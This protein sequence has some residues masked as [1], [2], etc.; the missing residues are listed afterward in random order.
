ML[1]PFLLPLFVVFPQGSSSSTATSTGVESAKNNL[2]S[3]YVNAW[4]NAGFGSDKLVSPADSQWVFRN[5]DSGQMA[6]A[7]SLGM[8]NAWD[9]SRLDAL[10]K[11]LNAEEENVRGGAV[12]GLALMACGTRN[13]D[14]DPMLALLGMHLEE[15]SG[16]G[17][18]MKIGA[19]YGLGLVY[20]GSAREDVAEL[21]TPY[22]AAASSSSSS[23]SSSAAAGAGGAGAAGGLGS[24]DLSALGAAPGTVGASNSPLQPTP[25]NA[26]F[27]CACMAALALGMVFVGTAKEDAASTIADR[28]MSATSNEQNSA[29]ARHMALG[30]GLLFLGQGEACEAMLEILTVV[31]EA[32]PALAKLSKTL[33]KSCAY[34]G[35]G[36]VLC[37]QELLQV[38]AAHPEIEDKEKDQKAKE[39]AD[40]K[41]AADAVAAGPR[42]AA[43]GAGAGA[44]AGG[45]GGAA[46]AA[47]AAAAASASS[48]SS[49]ASADNKH[50]ANAAG[51]YLDQS[52]AVLGLALVSLGEDLSVD[53]ATRM[54]DHLLQYG[55]TSVRR[56]VPI[57]LGLLHASEPDYAIVDTLSKLSHDPNLET[58]QAAIF[59]M[60]IVSAG[61]NNS[62]VAG[63][64]RT[65]SV[66]YKDDPNVLFVIRLAQGLTHMGKGLIGLNPI[67]ADRNLLSPVALA[68]LLSTLLLFL[69]VKSSL[70]GTSKWHILLYSLA[71]T[72]HPRFVT[73]ISEDL[74]DAKPMPVEVRVGTAVDTVGQAGRPKT[75]TGFQTHSTPVLIGTKDRAELVDE[76]FYPLTPII[77]GIVIL[78]KN[79]HYKPQ[80]GKGTMA[81]AIA[82]GAGAGGAGG[83]NK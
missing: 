81:G 18:N 21:L 44:G 50:G 79:P 42:G 57:A 49:D 1:S 24:L 61:T 30:L 14:V 78:R 65:L 55:D 82:G 12:L 77:E 73:T 46:A 29:I 53:M 36:N 19:L 60:G 2:A 35:T 9:E 43:G 27:D 76:A 72:M 45:A 3:T 25:S 13:L 7:A 5:K 83:T 68:G 56:M 69:D 59:S 64:L 20:A 41:V 37:I 48:S 70:H 33:L 17:Q 40:R 22:I 54:A 10:D 39:E 71:M 31:E 16:A 80:K 47:A 63:L 4:V 66:F 58:A 75:I 15:G 26:V 11:Y 74:A 32:A 28:L 62:R 38:C 67:H 34:A 6:A 8:I 52:T 23:S 51:R